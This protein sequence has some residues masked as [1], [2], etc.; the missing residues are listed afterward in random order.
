MQMLLQVLTDWS[1]EA[2]WLFRGRELEKQPTT[3]AGAQDARG[4]KA[5]EAT[6]SNVRNILAISFRMRYKPGCDDVEFHC[7]TQLPLPSTG[8]ITVSHISV[9]E[10]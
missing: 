7:T 10:S 8:T 9:V 1:V 3:T 5:S 6:Y 4:M 2:P